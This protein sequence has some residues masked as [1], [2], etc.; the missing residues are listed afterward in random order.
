MATKKFSEFDS[1]PTPVLADI[2]LVGLDDAGQNARFPGSAFDGAAWGN[3]TGTLADQTDLNSALNGK[4]DSLGNPGTNGYVLSSTTDGV[5]SWVPQ[6]DSAAWG[7]ITGDI[8]D[9]TDLM[10]LRPL[11]PGTQEGEPVL[12]VGT[13]Q[14][15]WLGIYA[16]DIS[17]MPSN[18]Q[19]YD[20]EWTRQSGAAS[21]FSFAVAN[22]VRTVLN[23]SGGAYDGSGVVVGMHGTSGAV[24]PGGS[25][26][27]GQ[28][29]GH[30]GWACLNTLTQRY[31][32]DF[33]MVNVAKSGE[34]ISGWDDGAEMEAALED[35]VTAA[36]AEINTLGYPVAITAPRR[37]FWLQGETNKAIPTSPENYATAWKTFKA[38]AETKWA[39][40]GFT[41]WTIFDIGDGYYAVGEWPAFP[42]IIEETA[43][44]VQLVSARGIAETF[45]VTYH[46]TGPGLN[47]YGMRG[48]DVV[49]TPGAGRTFP[50]PEASNIQWQWGGAVSAVEDGASAVAF[51]FDTAEAY[52]TSGA[53]IPGF[54]NN[55]ALV[56]SIDKDGN[57]YFAGGIISREATLGSPITLRID[58][59]SARDLDYYSEGGLLA[60]TVTSLVMGS[61]NGAWISSRMSAGA[62]FPAI[63]LVASNTLT[64]S[65]SVLAAGDVANIDL[66]TLSRTGLL[67]TEGGYSTDGD[68]NTTVGT[69]VSSVANGG[70]AVAFDLDTGVAY[71]TTAKLLRLRNNGTE[72]VSFGQAGDATL[73]GGLTA[74]SGTVTGQFVR[75][76]SNI[77]ADNLAG[78]GE[79]NVV[80]DEDGVLLSV[81]WDWITATSTAQTTD[82]A[83][84]QLLILGTPADGARESWELLVTGNRQ[85]TAG[86]VFASL[87]FTVTRVGATCV[88]SSSPEIKKVTT[89]TGNTTTIDVGAYG[90]GFLAVVNGNASETWDWKAQYR[91]RTIS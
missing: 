84:P 36:I 89:G 74:A 62:G 14:S 11:F 23:A 12:C 73:A 45:D 1:V 5:R 15:N 24:L 86:T 7:A 54:Y 47:A 66:L 46:F 18:S 39:V 49:D 16:V 33:F 82:A 65:S 50:T 3:I 31:R 52:V 35:H 10:E 34:P 29:S 17:D 30:I 61:T 91:H 22:P 60:N 57:A 68:F 28:P 51:A 13:G 6:S 55:G 44:D 40:E 67:H 32:N 71:T 78:T 88:V 20:W 53:I 27:P 76:T 4:E 19:I 21:N 70:S 85:T 43:N 37:V 72:V 77:T 81:G 75:G 38:L 80:A 79:R 42:R 41:Q 90:T 87:I 59:T 69:F 83:T 56:G 48:A 64:G 8:T 63:R 2:E 9:Q 58:G 25:P 26:A